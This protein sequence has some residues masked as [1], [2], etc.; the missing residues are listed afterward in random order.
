MEKIM[1]I[2]EKIN[3]STITS[4][5]LQ[6]AILSSAIERRYR[7]IDFLIFLPAVECIVSVLE[8]LGTTIREY[9]QVDTLNPEHIEHLCDE[10]FSLPH[11]ARWVKQ[12]LRSLT[13]EQAEQAGFKVKNKDGVYVSGEG[14]YFPFTREFGQLRLDAPIERKNGSVAKYLTPLGAKTKARIPS[15]CKVVTEGAKDAVAGSLRGG[16]PTGAIAGISHYRKALKQDAGYTVLFDADGWINPAVFSN[17]FHA[18]KWLNGKVQLI[19]E[20]EG[21]P[22]AGLCEYFKVGN[23]TEDYKELVDSAKKPEALLL[24]WESI[25]EISQRRNYLKRYE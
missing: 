3:Q 10:G 25:L 15:G 14:L 13:Q 16:I 5:Q 6:I 7:R 4:L 24:Q 11:V 8:D 1:Q 9:A 22:K 12:G 18:G 17:L 21:Y 23:T 20:I 2:T 19:P